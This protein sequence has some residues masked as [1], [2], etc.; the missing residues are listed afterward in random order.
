M[1]L[2]LKAI[3]TAFESKQTSSE[4]PDFDRLY[5][6]HMLSVDSVKTIYRKGV[7]RKQ[8]ELLSSCFSLRVLWSYT[9]KQLKAFCQL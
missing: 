7:T 8:I 4:P 2:Y 3:K 6:C 9:N 1:W 5:V